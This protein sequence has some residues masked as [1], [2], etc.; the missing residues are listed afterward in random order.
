[1]EPLLQKME[2]LLILDALVLILLLTLKKNK[3][4][5][6]ITP[7]RTPEVI[8]DEVSA[9]GGD[10]TIVGRSK[11]RTRGKRSGLAGKTDEYGILVTT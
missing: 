2:P 10:S 3:D 7:E 1:M 8:E 4:D 6:A 5:P 11:R 9:G